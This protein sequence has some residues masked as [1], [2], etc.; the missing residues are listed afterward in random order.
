MTLSERFDTTE[1]QKVRMPSIMAH[2]SELHGSEVGPKYVEK[3]EIYLPVLSA[4]FSINDSRLSAKL[5]TEKKEKKKKKASMSA[6]KQV[7]VGKT[8]SRSNLNALRATRASLNKSR[9]PRIKKK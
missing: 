1:S 4:R 3:S 2:L 6:M 5:S 8:S 7:N 9:S